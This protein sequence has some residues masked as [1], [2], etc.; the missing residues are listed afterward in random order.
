MDDET[1]AAVTGPLLRSARKA[2]GLTLAQVSAQVGL[3]VT[4]LSRLEAG[5]RQ[6]SIGMLMK[7]A[8]SYGTGV[9]ELLGESTGTVH[10]H[11]R[12]SDRVTRPG[13]D[14]PFGVLTGAPNLRGLHAVELSLDPEDDE[15][16]ST[17]D[18]E[19][20]LYVVSGALTLVLG[21]QQLALTEGD[22]VH[23]DARVRHRLTKHSPDTRVVIVCAPSKAA[24]A[25]AHTG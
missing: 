10:H 24:S 9:G 7:L 16:V 3:S 4:H 21:E 22:A 25:G 13:P 14:G 5:K 12:R 2:R 1:A 18:D 8:Q 11:S 17:H 15:H 19:E 23:F 20:V 6:P